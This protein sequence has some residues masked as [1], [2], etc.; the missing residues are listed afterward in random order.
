M[1]NSLKKLN[2]LIEFRNL[3]SMKQKLL[4]SGILV[5]ILT[6]ISHAQ[7]IRGHITNEQ[8]EAIAFATIYVPQTST[9]TVSN[10]DGGYELKLQEGNCMVEVKY[11]GYKTRSFNL[12]IGPE[13]QEFDIQLE[14]QNYH[15]PEV[16]V[17]ASGEDPAYYIM[18][19][20][21]A[22]APYYEKQV[23][24]YSC[25]VYLKGSGVFGKIPFIFEKQMKKDG[26][27]E[28]EPFVMETLSKI[29]FE[30]PDK[31]NQQVLAMRSTGRDNNTSPMGMITNNLYNA[32]KYGVVSPLGKN[33]LKN[34]AFRL[35]SVFEDQG[36]TINKILVT[37]KI[38][39][40][41]VF[42]G[43]LYIADDYWNIY[44]ADLHLHIPMTDVQFHQVYAEVSK[45]VWMPVG[46]DFD[47]DFSGLGFKIKYKY[48]ASVSDYQ[49]TL[50]PALDHSFL[51]RIKEK[52][53]Q[54]Q[55]FAEK[56]TNQSIVKSATKTSSKIN[57]LMAKKELSNSET[58]KLNRLIETE[59]R[60]QSP[61]EPLEIMSAVKVSQKQVNNDSAYWSELRPV[62]LTG[63]EKK[64]FAAKDSFLVVSQKPE[65]QDSVKNAKRRFKVKHLI[66]GKTY[67]YSKDSTDMV[68]RFTIP[69]IT[70]PGAFSF[71][72]VDGLRVEFPFNYTLADTT[73]HLTRF[74]PTLAYGFVRRKLDASLSVQHRLN[75]MSRAWISVSGGTTTADFNR[76]SPLS[77][78][79]ND[80]YTLWLEEN[81]KRYYRRDFGQV[82]FR[83]DIH[84]GLTINL[85]ADYS[86]NIALT[87]H[88]SY[89][90]IDYENK[91]IRPNI[92]ENKQMEP[93]QLLSHQ[94][95]VGRIELEYTPRYRYRVKNQVK[96]YAES[97]YPTF[98]LIYRGGFSGIAGSDSRYDLL[99]AGIRQQFHFGIDD[100][101]NYSLTAGTFLNNESVFFEDF[102]H[103]NTQ[104]TGFLFA[105]YDNSFRLLPFYGYSTQ[106]SF[107]E[108]HTNWQ[109]RRMVVKL[110]P[111]FRNSALL[112]EAL[113]VNMLFTPEIKN[114]A[115]IGYG[116]HNL[117]L[118]F[119]VEAVAGF[120][121]GAYRSA[122][123]K[124][125]MNLK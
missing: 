38:N 122:G 12:N 7:G 124:V 66:F 105:S 109:T 84:N 102:Q 81:Y 125:S 117:L 22:M 73:D 98:N 56:S 60:R 20:A 75:G 29:D 6:T 94:S 57:S 65:Y 111:V 96:T 43:F 10:A 112:S 37:P 11:L 97:R 68:N 40:N 55:A 26:V 67:D 87:N 21:I 34:Y 35:T 107:T 95:M 108:T 4:L 72:S 33:A 51:D 101:F 100:H 16:K 1:I 45:N 78:L 53:F 36:R 89:S 83:R 114:Y 42:S 104:P 76:T 3:C 2:F 8:G 119:N 24:K 30:L 49:T 31:L 82:M 58:R 116:L 99:K 118:L 93:W 103:F 110:L 14:T 28:N 32:E 71:N 86:N 92:P 25:K 91:Q 70:D 19:R 79:T 121:N 39:S 115:E 88:T 13:F 48:V 80:L 54:E 69:G 47:M 123:I 63:P 59:T 62:P 77:V 17:M 44:S 15:I 9:G 120:E 5:F 18:R 46:L 90:F 113:F 61:P 74:Q 52:Q 64:S 41:D 50:N 106:K 85:M 27:K 23:S